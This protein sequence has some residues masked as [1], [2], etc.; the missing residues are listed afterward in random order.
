MTQRS[1]GAIEFFNVMVFVS[2]AAVS[3]GF[4][5]SLAPGEQRIVYGCKKA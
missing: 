3:E 4:P 2:N 5:D 1:V